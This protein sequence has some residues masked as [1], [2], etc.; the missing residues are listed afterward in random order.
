MRTG[1]DVLL[2]IAPVLALLVVAGCGTSTGTVEHPLQEVQFIA[3]EG[4]TTPLCRA[5]TPCDNPSRGRFD[6]VA[7]GGHHLV[8][9]TDGRGRVV[10]DIPAGDIS[11]RDHPEP[12]D[13]RGSRRSL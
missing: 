2:R 12:F 4:P 7:A 10:A 11:D 13:S 1:T 5:S 9:T 8:M 3:R 6:L